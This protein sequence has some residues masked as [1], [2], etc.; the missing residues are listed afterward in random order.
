MAAVSF[1]PPAALPPG[2][3]PRLPLATSLAGPLGAVEKSLF[4]Q[5]EIEPRFLGHQALASIA[6]PRYLSLTP[7]T[8]N[9]R[10]TVAQLGRYLPLSL[11]LIE[12]TI[13]CCAMSASFGCVYKTSCA[14][15]TQRD[16]LCGGQD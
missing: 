14:M 12:K 1:N 9:H 8:S 4:S 3:E 16:L 7:E 11:N 13:S 10:T 6:V 15:V 5:P 2:N